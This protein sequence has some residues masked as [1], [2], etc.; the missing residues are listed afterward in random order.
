MSKFFVVFTSITCIAVTAAVISC[1]SL[2]GASGGVQG[3]MEELASGVQVYDASGEEFKGEG[4]LR[5]RFFHYKDARS[6]QLPVPVK[7]WF[8]GINEEELSTVIGRV[9]NGIV[10]VENKF[11][12]NNI[13]LLVPDGYGLQS[14]C[15]FEFM[16]NGEHKGYLYFGNLPDESS[17]AF[18]WLNIMWSNNDKKLNS[19]IGAAFFVKV[20]LRTGWNWL[21]T[22]KNENSATYVV[23]HKKWKPDAQWNIIFEK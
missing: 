13:E 2:M 1:Q 18:S 4:E 21:H 22:A 15:R 8:F 6:V 11:W 19:K 20:K 9:S 23:S 5:V 7:T 16:E 3:I 12:E 10:K 14:V 17:G